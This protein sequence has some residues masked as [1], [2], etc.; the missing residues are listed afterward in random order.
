MKTGRRIGGERL[1]KWRRRK[2]R[3]K[4]SG[5]REGGIGKMKMWMTGG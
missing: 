5:Q 4:G 3:G 1:N 2:D